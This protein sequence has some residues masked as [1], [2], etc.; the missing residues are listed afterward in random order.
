M[1]SHS[2]S[3]FA[4]VSTEVHASSIVKEE[5]GGSSSREASE[6]TAYFGSPSR[7]PDPQLVNQVSSSLFKNYLT[8][9]LDAKGKELE[10]KSKIEKEAA[11]FKF[12]QR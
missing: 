10:G 3:P 9:Q 5:N 12:G 2:R 4:D 11:E 8:N 1:F 6:V 7:T